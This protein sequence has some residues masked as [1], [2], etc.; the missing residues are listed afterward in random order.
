MTSRVVFQGLWA[1]AI[2]WLSAL[3][4]AG[5]G[6]VPDRPKTAN[7]P[8]A[9]PPASSAAVNEINQ[10][11]SMLASQTN[12]SPADYRIGPDDLIQITIYN[13]PEQEA[14]ITP[15]TVLLR[16]SQQGS[17]VAPLVGELPIGGMTTR[18][19][20][21]ELAKRYAKYIRDPQIGVLVTEYR[22]RVSV[23]GA[24]QKPGVFELTGPKSVIDMLALAGGVTEKA[25]NQVHLYRQDSQGRRQSAVIDLLVLAS[26]GSAGSL[27]TGAD[28]AAVNM[29]VQG[30][31]VINVP[32]AGTFFVDGAVRKPGSYPL[33]R[34][35]TLTQALAMAGGAD[36]EL[37]DYDE[38][39]IYRRRGPANTETITVDLTAVNRGAKD[40]TIE[41]DDVILVPM[42]GVKYFVKRFV[43]TIISGVSFGSFVGGS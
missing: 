26:G 2:A 40:P 38:I 33:G 16:V 22:Q 6:A 37:A 1:L 28:A 9:D 34:H 24:V 8:S 36:P 14:R 12:S 5:C 10:S 41:P 17:V 29:P 30:G 42:S 19:A 15:R 39:T 18:E 21:R 7:L 27:A 3:V 25:G 4:A 20:E 23:M 43:G 35:Y 11:L 32:H 13:I 31:D